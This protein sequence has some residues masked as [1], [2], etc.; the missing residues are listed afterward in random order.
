MLKRI[1]IIILAVNSWPVLSFAQS[2]YSV[3]VTNRT[4]TI[5]SGKSDYTFSGNFTIV[6][7]DKDP[8]MGLRPAGLAGVP[9][10]VPTWKAYP[11][12]TADLKQ[13]KKDASVGGDGFDNKILTGAQA[14][15]TIQILNAGIEQ[16]ITPTSIFQK[17][18][19][20]FFT[21]KTDSLFDFTAKIVFDKKKKQAALQFLLTPRVAGYFSSGYNGAPSFLI[22]KLKE[23]WQPLIW[24]EMRFP[25]KPYLTPAHM[26]PIPATMVNDGINT[27]GVMAAPEHLP[28]NP[29]PLITN[30]QFGVSLRNRDGNA[31]PALYAPVMGGMNSKMVVGDS[32]GFQFYLIVEPQK[33]TSVYEALASGFFG[34]KDYRKNDIS[35]LNKT[36]DN[37]VAYSLSKYALFVDSLK[38][39]AYSTD[40]PG[41]VKNVS[42]LNPIEL[43]IVMDDQTMFDKRGYPLIEFMLSREKFLFSLDSNQKIQSPSRKLKGPVAPVSELGSLY[44]IF[45]QKNPSLLALADAEF[46]NIR[47]RNLESK[48]SGTNWM[49][50]MYL[51]QATSDKKYLNNAVSGADEYLRSRVYQMQS[52]FKD[53]MA[54]SLFFWPSFTNKW[55]DLLSLYEITGNRKYLAAAQDGARHYAMFT[56]MTPAIPEGD[57]TVNKGGKAP[58]YWYLKAKGH[59]PMFYAEEN[60]PAWRLSETGLTPESSGTSSGHRAIFMANYAPWMLRLG[61]YANDS[62]LKNIAK[63][64]IIG[65]SRNFPGYHIN[66]ERTTA[67]EKLDFPLHNHKDQSVS[68]FHYNHILPMASMLLDY[69][70]T[71][72]FV[73][74]GGKVNFPS[75]FI[76]GYAYLQNKF[77]GAKPGAFY[78]EKNIQLWMPANLITTSNVELNYIS[79]R[80]DNNLFI[81]FTNQ[82]GGQVDASVLLDKN[83]L[84][85]IADSSAV[86][87]MKNDKWNKV[88]QL[89]ANSF[90]VT[91][92]ANGIA[93]VK[94]DRIKP[95]VIFQNRVLADL[96]VVKNDEASVALGNTKAYT[97][98]F[99]KLSKAFVYLQDD[100]T[101]FSE[102]TISYKIKGKE[103]VSLKDNAYPFEFTIDL[104]E[105]DSYFEFMLDAVRRDGSRESSAFIKLGTQ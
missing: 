57:V 49:N 100:D 13:T 97:F 78:D 68:S 12:K 91:V 88:Q 9:Y 77:Y 55:I 84:I 33:I 90:S 89:T 36:L 27:I 64:A 83:L 19:T 30:S 26:C 69:L 66:T 10:N 2:S 76:E 46:N 98:R 61:Y 21:Y 86:F 59:K 53:T 105:S 102:V 17:S 52:S 16:Q 73:R 85:P 95:T 3:N 71:D 7:S 48:E 81:A 62:Y 56:Y 29:L 92:P 43:A 82:S 35:T 99:G 63:A 94:I 11:G 101:R 54:G 47:E 15:R 42:S 50:A 70:V 51:Y 79:G 24:Q 28:F 32:F 39:C 4:V 23:L 18:D 6:Y 31:Q 75:E 38:G 37:I 40:V 104:P 65:R 87:V 20:V 74:S 44:T 93:V 25:D 14:G 22:S 96:S 5:S 60:A 1:I 80:K 58:V 8:D 72:V 34:F 41:A 103:L 67:Y 45:G